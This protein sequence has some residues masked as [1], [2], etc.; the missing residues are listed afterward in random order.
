MRI[1]RHSRCSRTARQQ[2]AGLRNQVAAAHRR[3]R[4]RLPNSCP[5]QTPSLAIGNAAQQAAVSPYG[6]T[7]QP[8]P[9]IPGQPCAQHSRISCSSSFRGSQ[10]EG[11]S[12]QR[13]RELAMDAPSPRICLRRAS[14]F[15]GTATR[16]V[17][18][19]DTGTARVGSAGAYGAA[20]G[21][22]AS[23]LI[24][25]RAAGDRLPRRSAGPDRAEARGQHRF[26]YGP[27]LRD[28]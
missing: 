4:N 17:P 8:A 27:A 28:L 10:E 5:C 13:N 19:E 9:C 16:A 25:P 18:L 7:G 11:S 1:S 15:S 23:S 12:R 6:P 20:P 24:A 26:S 22:T 14:P 21:Q 3:L 2:R